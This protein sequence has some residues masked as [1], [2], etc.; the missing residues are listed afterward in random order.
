MDIQQALQHIQRMHETETVRR[1][2]IIGWYCFYAKKLPSMQ[3]ERSDVDLSRTIALWME[4][5]DR[6][7]SPGFPHDYKSALSF[8][9]ISAAE[10]ANPNKMWLFGAVS[11]VAGIV[12]LFFN[13]K[14]GLGRHAVGHGHWSDM[15]AEALFYGL[16]TSLV[17]YDT[18]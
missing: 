18:A 8:P 7:G 14:I 16:I 4:L 13:W 17:F 6:G 11:F 3:L 15:S 12:I 10:P 5:T 1:E 9:T 2:S